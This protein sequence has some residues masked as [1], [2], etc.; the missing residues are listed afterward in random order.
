MIAWD[1]F[2]FNHW[3]ATV[4]YPNTFDQHQVRQRL[5]DLGTYD[6]SIAVKPFAR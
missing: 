4:F 5:I 3:V 1:V 2:K 6:A